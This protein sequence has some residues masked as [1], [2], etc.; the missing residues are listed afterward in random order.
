[1]KIIDACKK[2]TNLEHKPQEGSI[3]VLIVAIMPVVLLFMGWSI[4]AGR[5][6]AAKAE[7]YKASDVAAREVAEEIDLREAA[8]SGSRNNYASDEDAMEWVEKNLDGLCGAELLDV[9]V[10][11]TE[12]YVEVESRA[13][14]P[15]LFSAL[16]NKRSMVIRTT[17]IGRIKVYPTGS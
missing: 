11:N 13:R 9:K 5:V 10:V 4:D 14:V 3:T 6:M 2:R 7:L 16:V 17:S 12:V 8:E 15:L 1:M